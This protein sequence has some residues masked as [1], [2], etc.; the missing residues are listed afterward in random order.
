MQVK[1]RIE[2]MIMISAFLFLPML[3]T[4]GLIAVTNAP[5]ATAIILQTMN[6]ASM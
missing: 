6:L 4:I 2:T 1:Q 3:P 5:L